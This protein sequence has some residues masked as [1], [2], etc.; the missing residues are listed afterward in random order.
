MLAADDI[1]AR[2]P[3]L[4]E[5]AKALMPSLPFAALDCLIVDRIGT[6]ISGNGMDS[7]IIGRVVRS[8]DPPGTRPHITRVVLR[9][10]TEASHGNAI[11]IGAADFTTT[12][13]LAAMDAEATAVNCITAMGPE[14]ARLPIAFDR[15]ED[16]VQAAYATCG[17]PSPEEFSLA[18][19]RDILSLEE[20]LVS[21]ALLPRIE[22]GERLEVL[23]EPFPLPVLG[24]GTLSPDWGWP[25]H[26]P[27][28]GGR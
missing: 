26:A 3:S 6:E 5:R 28:T 2:E 12:R 11:G 23:G 20:L 24:D 21:T 16:A 4:L 22:A 14:A 15:D 27:T 17:A 25:R 10:L 19:V 7:K 18:W 1:I 8:G 13:L 9:D